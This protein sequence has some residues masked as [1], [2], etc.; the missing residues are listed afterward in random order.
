MT[1]KQKGIIFVTVQ[2]ILI[3]LLVLIPVDQSSELANLLAPLTG[4]TGAEGLRRLCGIG[5][6]LRQG[7]RQPAPGVPPSPSPRTA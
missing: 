3:A 6:W 2:F 5:L 1:D 4:A 7:G